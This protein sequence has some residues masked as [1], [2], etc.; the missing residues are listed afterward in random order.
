MTTT[1][2]YI[3]GTVDNVLQAQMDSIVAAHTTFGGERDIAIALA[4][5]L[6]LHGAPRSRLLAM[7]IYYLF[8]R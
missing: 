1:T 2:Q 7:L 8:N 3:T 5:A 6:T 4:N